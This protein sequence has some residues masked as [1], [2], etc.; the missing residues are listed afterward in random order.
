MLKHYERQFFFL[1]LPLRELYGYTE[2]YRRG[3]YSKTALF[4]FCFCCFFVC[5]FIF[6]AFK[7][8]LSTAKARRELLSLRLYVALTEICNLRQLSVFTIKSFN[9]LK[10]L[11]FLNSAQ[12]T[13]MHAYTF[14]LVTCNVTLF[15]NK[16]SC[17]NFLKTFYLVIL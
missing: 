8:H 4:N 7:N 17:C 2:I 3:I 5:L 1:T 14:P 12:I 10:C 9:D 11:N 16:F 15:L 13:Y 6:Q